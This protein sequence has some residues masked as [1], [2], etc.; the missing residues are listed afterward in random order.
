MELANA[1]RKLFAGTKF[2]TLQPFIKLNLFQDKPGKT[3][4][5]V[6]IFSEDL[7]IDHLD[8]EQK[9]KLL[10]VLEETGAVENGKHLEKT[11]LVEHAINTGGNP[12]VRQ[13]PYRF[14]QVKQKIIEE[15]GR[16]C[17]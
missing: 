13:Q 16:K 2:A 7:D 11:S 3:G 4:K 15:V 8:E 12:S 10:N 9:Q 1:T 17:L 5:S 6:N 14:P